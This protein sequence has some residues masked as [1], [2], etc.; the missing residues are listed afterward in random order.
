[1]RANRKPKNR[2]KMSTVDTFLLWRKSKGHQLFRPKLTAM[3]CA[4]PGVLND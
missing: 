4:V 2:E 3:L 1:M